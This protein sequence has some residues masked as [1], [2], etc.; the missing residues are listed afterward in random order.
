MLKFYYVTFFYLYGVP[1]D[2][3]QRILTIAH[4]GY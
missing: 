1:H 4:K 2:R 3:A